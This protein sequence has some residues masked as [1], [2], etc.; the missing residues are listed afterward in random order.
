MG[1]TYYRDTRTHYQP[2]VMLPPEQFRDF[3]EQVE[4]FEDWFAEH[5]YDRLDVLASV[6]W[7]RPQLRKVYE[8]SGSHLLQAG[9]LVRLHGVYLGVT[10]FE[11]P[12]YLHLSAH[13][14]KRLALC[15]GDTVE[16]RATP[17]LRGSQL[18]LTGLSQVSVVGRDEGALAGPD[19]DEALVKRLVA[20]PIPPGAERCL[21]C[22]RAVLVDVEFRGVRA[23]GP[24][25]ELYC[26]EGV[27]EHALCI[28]PVL[29]RLQDE[30]FGLEECGE[31][32]VLR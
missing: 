20:T 21:S 22:T 30:L 7:V 3:L 11:D 19:G 25:R 15:P 29:D 31:G 17:A 9:F 24:A 1:C 2:E 23:R 27:Q 28:V 32:D 18:F 12:I 26:L 6:S 13:Q 10:A 4:E 5:R 16:L 8:K 14:Q